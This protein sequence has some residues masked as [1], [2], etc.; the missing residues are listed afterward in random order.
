[1]RLN[2]HFRT[3]CSHAGTETAATHEV[4]CPPPRRSAAIASLVQAFRSR[5]PDNRCTLKSFAL[6]VE[7]CYC[8]V[9]WWHSC[10]RQNAAR[11][12]FS[13]KRS[14]AWCAGGLKVPRHAVAGPFCTASRRRT[15]Q[16]HC[17]PHRRSHCR[18]PPRSSPRARGS[19]SHPL[20]APVTS[21]ADSGPVPGRKRSP[22]CGL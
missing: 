14:P 10:K 17:R 20:V 7:E 18:P 11:R 8:L 22:R 16:T 19:H 4:K 9:L 5:L 1:M 2:R 6:V 13:T 21:R 3:S 15:H 12:S